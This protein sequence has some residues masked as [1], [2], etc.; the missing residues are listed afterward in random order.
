M[1]EKKEEMIELREQG[2]NYRQ[3][4]EIYHIS[5]QRVHSIIGKEKSRKNNADIER[6]VYKGIYD[7]LT[8][9]PK[10]SLNTLYRKISSNYTSNQMR[11]FRVFLMNT[12]DRGKLTIRQIKKLIEI[13]GKSFDE[14]FERR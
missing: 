10:I 12:S 5:R 7:Y 14:L 9:N 2:L 11:N 3:I 1:I 6:I 13:T 4:S 8:E